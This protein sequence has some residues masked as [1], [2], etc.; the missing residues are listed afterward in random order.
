MFLDL[1]QS[2]FCQK[3]NYRGIVCARHFPSGFFLKAKEVQMTSNVG[4]TDRIIRIAAGLILIALIFVGP[5]TMWGWIGL[6]P[7]FTGIFRWCPAYRLVGIN[8]CHT[9]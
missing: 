9:S 3:S 4:N 1:D 8:S 5:K 2:P 7:L 6:V